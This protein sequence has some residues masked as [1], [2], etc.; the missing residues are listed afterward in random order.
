MKTDR[1]TFLA[2]IPA[3][4]A[5]MAASRT[6]WAQAAAPKG[7][8]RKLRL[9]AGQGPITPENMPYL[10]GERLGFNAQE[11]FTIEFN[12]VGSNANV[13]LGLANG[14]LDIGVSSS[15]AYMP[16]SVKGQMPPIVTIFECTY[17]YKYDIVVLPD[18]PI[19]TY[20]D[21]K[22]KKMGITELGGSTYPVSRRA[23]E[24]AGVDP[25]TGVQG[26]IAVGGGASGGAALRSKTIDALAD[27]DTHLG[28][29]EA[30][31]IPFRV[32]PRPEHLKLFGGLF[33][34]VSRSFLQNNRAL[35]IGYCRSYAKACHF[36]LANPAAG[37]KAFLEQ[38]PDMAIR[39]QPLE[40]SIQALAYSVN[41]RKV[42]YHPPYPNTKPGIIS[43]EELARDAEFLQLKI[44]DFKQFYT[45]ELNAEINNFDVEAIAKMAKAYPV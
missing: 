3:S 2:G 5:A 39:G 40:K 25:E 41:R 12:G 13:M 33:L 10:V 27:Y 24:T 32:L 7:E 34:T 8:L 9:G 1:R 19:K 36:I 38:F 43:E 42:I 17:P 44:T 28:E 6:A 30:A 4:L 31:G 20:A 23:I 45:N 21:L 26:W 22:G 18:S 37:I 35:A 16:L 29:L 15:T 11:G 14:S